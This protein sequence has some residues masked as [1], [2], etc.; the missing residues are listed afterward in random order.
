MSL[1]QTI[2]SLLAE[3][4][5][6]TKSE[7]VFG[8]PLTIGDTTIIPITKIYLGFAAGGVGKGEGTGGGVQVTPVGIVSIKDGKVEITRITPAV[9]SLKYSTG[10]LLW[11]E[12]L[13]QQVLLISKSS[14]KDGR[15][16][17]A[18]DS[19]QGK[20][21]ASLTEEL[22]NGEILLNIYAGL[23]TGRIE[24]ISNLAGDNQDEQ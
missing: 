4:K 5:N 2:E 3:V 24:I 18:A 6:I 21:V 13:T 23:V 8:D 19:G 22:A 16:R 7:T 11:Q 9:Y 17:M 15:F 20:P 1:S 12:N 10:L 14:K